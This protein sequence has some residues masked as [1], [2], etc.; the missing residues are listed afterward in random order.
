[1][2]PDNQ[3]QTGAS[4]FGATMLVLK[5]SMSSSEPLLEFRQVMALDW[6]LFSLEQA[7]AKQSVLGTNGR[8]F[9]RPC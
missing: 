5:L 2:I 7:G 6:L 1:M 4:C 3:N 8:Q 9:L